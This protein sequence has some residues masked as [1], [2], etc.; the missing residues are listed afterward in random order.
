MSPAGGG[1]GGGG[2]DEAKLEQAETASL[3]SPSLSSSAIQEEFS[4][5]AIATKNCPSHEEG[6]P[7]MLLCHLKSCP[8][9][10]AD[11]STPVVEIEVASEGKLLKEV[12][13]KSG[14][15]IDFQSITATRTALHEAASKASFL[16]FSGHGYGDKGIGFE[17]NG[18]T[19]MLSAKEVQILNNSRSLLKLVCLCSCK[20]QLVG[21]AFVGLGV[22][23]VVAVN[24]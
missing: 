6:A 19:C 13:A 3:F 1:G 14:L 7:S 11:G 20:S 10:E 4:P 2:G 8:L 22:L 21:E 5:E 18:K 23:H 16:H 9:V 24:K 17:D 15:D 12:A